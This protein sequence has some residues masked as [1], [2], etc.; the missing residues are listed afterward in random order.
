MPMSSSSAAIIRSDVRV[1]WPRSMIDE[2]SVTVLSAWT[3]KYESTWSAD[4]GGGAPGAAAEAPLASPARPRLK[5][6]ISTPPP[7]RKAFRENCFSERPPA[8]TEP[9]SSSRNLFRHHGGGL[10]DRPQDLWVR[11]APTQMAV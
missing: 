4:M 7:F 9:L 1:P 11:P 10:L 5:P 3:V 6:T 2:Y 8:I